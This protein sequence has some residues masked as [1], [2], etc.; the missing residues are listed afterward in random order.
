MPFPN[1][2]SLAYF[3]PRSQLIFL[4][5]INSADI[6]ADF[7]ANR[8]TSIRQSLSTVYHEVTHWADTVGTLWGNEYL[9]QVYSTYDVMPSINL[10]GS[11]ARFHRFVDLHD[12]DRR[13]SFSDYYRTVED[14]GR[15]HSLS[16][17]W[18]I[19]F[20]CGVEFNSSGRPD[21]KRPVIFVR[22]GDHYSEQLL[23]RQPLSVAAL[24][25]TTA[26]WSEL[27][28]QFQTLSALNQDERMVE[29]HF[30]RKEYGERLY[31]P[32]LTLYSAPIHLLA[33]YARLQNSVVAYHL[34]SLLSLVCL[35]LVGTHFRKLNIPK[36]LDAWGPRVTAFVRTES[37]PFAFMCLCMNGPD[38]NDD[39]APIDWVN[40]ALSNSG[41]PT[42]EEVLG[43][44]V[45]VLKEDEALCERPTMSKRQQYLRQVGSEWLEWRRTEMDTAVNY[46]HVSEKNLKLPVIFDASAKPFLL[47]GSD[48][49]IG[50]FDPM[51][52]FEEE[53]SLHTQSLNFRR[54]C[55]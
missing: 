39:M 7:A 8:L 27:S 48:F 54:A 42:Y 20:S 9:K 18:K 40:K 51:E 28:T 22:F 15:Q 45:K 31:T 29:E 14:N 37:R 21:E 23:V 36:D 49:D 10:P 12:S 3:V 55:R 4:N 11:E 34:G 6:E 53:A 24:L 32:E 41:L 25:E 50:I 44:A 38:W 1:T 43:H 2:K 13:L 17:P 16:T 46:S 52:M 30:L 26:T 47:F 33:H 19:S 5:E 35:N